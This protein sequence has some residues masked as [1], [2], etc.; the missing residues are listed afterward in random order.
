MS[1]QPSLFLDS[2]CDAIGCAVQTI[3][4]AKKASALLWPAMK[5]ETAYTRLRHCLADEFPE[6]LS[7]D[8]V[9]LLARHA[10]NLGDH[11]IMQYLAVCLDYEIRPTNP[12]E[13]KARAKRARKLALIAELA[14]LEEGEE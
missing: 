10:R 13:A 3:G 9:L 2:I 6:K 1:E 11:S 12:D 5:A 4:G 7:P 14:R 8:E